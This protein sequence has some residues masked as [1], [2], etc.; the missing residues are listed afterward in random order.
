MRMSCILLGVGL[1]LS[2]CTKR[3]TVEAPAVALPGYEQDL[4]GLTYGSTSY[5]D[6]TVRLDFERDAL[7]LVA[8]LT[9]V[10]DGLVVEFDARSEFF[11]F[12]ASLPSYLVLTPRQPWVWLPY[13]PSAS[14]AYAPLLLDCLLYTGGGTFW[15]PSGFDNFA[16][17][18]PVATFFFFRVF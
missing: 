4:L 6:W 11:P 8:V 7:G 17:T 15:P 12:S 18:N 3:S 13:S 9:R 2:G 14:A 5:G 16:Q 1:S 10:D